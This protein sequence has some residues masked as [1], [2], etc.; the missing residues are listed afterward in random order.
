MRLF[1]RIIL[2][3]VLCHFSI[4]LAAESDSIHFYISPDGNDN[5]SGQLVSPKPDTSDGPFATIQ[6]ARD[7]IR[8]LKLAGE[9]DAPV[10][11]F[12]RSGYYFLTE[13]LFFEPQDSGETSQKITYRAYPGEQPVISGGHRLENWEHVRNNRWKCQ[14]PWVSQDRIFQQLFINDERRFRARTPNEGYYRVRENIGLPPN[15]SYNTPQDK[16]KFFPGDII[17]GWRN[18]N[19]V[20]IVVLHFWVDTH[21]PIDSVDIENQ[22][23]RFSK[24]SRR[25]FTDDFSQN[26]ARY[27]VDNVYAGMDQ[28]GEWYLEQDTGMLTY[29]AKEEE[30]LNQA[31]VFAPDADQLF[32]VQGQPGGPFVQNL[33]FE[34]LTFKHTDWQ[35]PPDDAGDHQAADTVPAA[36][37]FIGSRNINVTNCRFENMGTCAAE[38]IDGCRHIRITHNKI[39]DLAGGGIKISGGRAGSDS[40]LHTNH[41]TVADN[42]I[43]ELGRL[44]HSSVGILLRHASDN[45]ISHNEIYDLYY[46]G[47]SVGWEWGYKPSAAYNNHITYNHIHHVGQDLLSDMGGVY[48]LGISPGT[49]VRNNLIHDISSHGYGGWGIYTDEGS[50]DILIE[51]NVVYNTKSAGFHQHY[52]RENVIQNNIFAFGQTAQVMRT[53]AEDHLS[54]TFRRN[55]VYWKDAP[56]LGKNWQGSG[57]K[58]DYN[59]YY[60]TD[61]KPVTFNGMSFA[62][63]QKRGQDIHSKIADP[64]FKDPQSYNFEL[65]PESP[66]FDLGFDLIDLTTVGPRE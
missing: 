13:P 59:L 40:V 35:L 56:L 61:N 49:V 27:Y 51:D 26:G 6:R 41:I 39:K 58:M 10:T 1:E 9:F 16:F 44:F 25:R 42:T 3:I 15:A 23:V 30:N 22:I 20:E 33:R 8:E 66:A 57:Y 18:L 21:L 24:K 46:T 31:E 47:I 55:I 50:T 17:A 2:I 65:L 19:D 34:G 60:R 32:I 48:L 52:G 38:V 28:D 29:L 53:R 5:W 62:E 11:V 63:W 43:G 4:T 64:L 12:L 14:V 36:L 54:F 7:A 37:H 45:N